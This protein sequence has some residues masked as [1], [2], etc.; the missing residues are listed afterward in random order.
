MQNIFF[1]FD[2]TLMDTSEGVYNA[3]DYVC[4]HYGIERKGSDFYSRLIGPPLLVSFRDAFCFEEERCHEALRVFRDYYTP[5]G[6]YQVKVY[7]G[8]PELLKK[9]SCAGKRIFVATSKPEVFAKEL[10]E[11][12]DLLKYFDFVGGC[13]VEETRVIKK[14]IINYVLSENKITDKEDCIMIGDRKFDVLGASEAG[15]KTLGILW[16]FGSKE[17]LLEAGAIDI[18]ETPAC[19]ADKLL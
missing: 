17:E 11:K 14:D 18:A 9:L 5:K 15:I 3:F 6:L 13:D 19:V 2:G 16:G 4:D 10:L 8:V 1:D 12:F 7:D